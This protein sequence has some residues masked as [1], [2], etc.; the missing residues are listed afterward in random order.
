M[1]AAEA[2]ARGETTGFTA[3]AA[4]NER[5]VAAPHSL[6]DYTTPTDFRIERHFPALYPTNVRPRDAGAGTR[7]F[8]PGGSRRAAQG[9]VPAI[10]I[11]GAQRASGKRSRERPL[12]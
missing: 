3:M 5:L 6:F 1:A 2:V 8:A 11:G 4:I 7:I 10:H 9:A 12:V